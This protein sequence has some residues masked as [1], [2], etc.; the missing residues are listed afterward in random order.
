MEPSQN[1]PEFETATATAAANIA[2]SQ[3]NID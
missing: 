3:R 1:N 2:S